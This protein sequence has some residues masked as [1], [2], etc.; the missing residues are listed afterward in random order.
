MCE[1]WTV[2]WDY[3]YAFVHRIGVYA[4]CDSTYESIFRLQPASSC[5]VQCQR[6]PVLAIKA[7][8]LL[9]NSQERSR[10]WV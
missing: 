8:S 7:G 9:P 2:H 5:G 1:D 3:S 10:G 4:G 6:R